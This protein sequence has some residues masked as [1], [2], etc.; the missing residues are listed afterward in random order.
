MNGLKKYWKWIALLLGL[1]G[2][3]VA[4]S[5]LPVGDWVKG[6]THWVRELGLAGAFIFIGVYA[7]A[8]LLFLPGAIFTNAA[9]LV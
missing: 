1:I 4:V 5:F 2:L 8:A 9:G 3:S 7:I 6:F